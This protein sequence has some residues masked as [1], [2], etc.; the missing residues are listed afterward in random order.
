MFMRPAK[1]I[2]PGDPLARLEKL[3]PPYI[4][5]VGIKNSDQLKS[6][7]QK[8]NNDTVATKLSE[9]IDV[10]K[11]VR[12]HDTK[13][14]N[15][16]KYGVGLISL[17]GQET[18][19]DYMNLFSRSIFDEGDAEEFINRSIRRKAQLLADALYEIGNHYSHKSQGST[20]LANCAWRSSDDKS[21]GII[22]ANI[23][24][25]Q[26]SVHLPDGT[27]QHLNCR[28]ILSRTNERKQIEKR[29]YQFSE[30]KINGKYVLGV[31]KEKDQLLAFQYG[32]SFI[33]NI[34]ADKKSRRT[35]TRGIGDKNLGR[36]Y[37]ANPS[38]SYLEV[39]IEDNTFILNY[40]K[41]IANILQSADI[42]KLIKTVIEKN[43]EDGQ[44][45]LAEKIAQ[46]ICEVAKA[47]GAKKN[48]AISV[49]P[50]TCLPNKICAM[51]WVAH[52][53]EGNVVS[54][55]MGAALQNCIAKTYREFKERE[56]LRNQSSRPY[57]RF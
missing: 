48:L 22:T 23:G 29:G 27:S 37:S 30:I 33:P 19:N 15:S 12:L 25:N 42:D 35:T 51:A 14:Q 36:V 10:E 31:M 53:H 49:I 45:R 55:E 7:L 52:G 2:R 54:K 8:A 9:K 18:Q 56:N 26:A 11:S 21:A 4:S 24:D 16:R 38:V 34:N 44:K 17:N 43:P 28:H 39:P 47:H 6:E 50:V 20:L 57:K 13:W 32:Q 1:I 40:N 41:H 3:K 46:S 5:N